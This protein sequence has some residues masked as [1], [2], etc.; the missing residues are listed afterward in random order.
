MPCGHCCQPRS[1]RPVRRCPAAALVLQKLESSQPHD[2]P[3]DVPATASHAGRPSSQST[4]KSAEPGNPSDLLPH[5]PFVHSKPAPSNQC[6]FARL[7][8]SSFLLFLVIPYTAALFASSAFF[9][10][11]ASPSLLPSLALPWCHNIP[12]AV[13]T[14]ARTYISTGKCQSV[15][16][17]SCS[18]FPKDYSFRNGAQPPALWILDHFRPRCSRL[19]LYDYSCSIHMSFCNRKSFIGYLDIPSDWLDGWYGVEPAY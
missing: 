12:A 6:I 1:T 2:G 11:R 10:Y 7:S 3:I 18:A 13:L 4:R 17:F 5:S 15:F 19:H 14:K 9:S 8:P 16:D